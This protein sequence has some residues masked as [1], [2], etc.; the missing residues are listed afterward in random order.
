MIGAVFA[1]RAMGMQEELPVIQMDKV[2]LNKIADGSYTG[3][4]L[5]K[6]VKVVVEVTVKDN[7]IIDI[8]IMKHDNGLGKKAE[9]IVDQIIKRQSLDV[10]V[11]SGATSSSKAILK[12]VEVAL[13]K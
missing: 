13:S 1:I 8:V 9:K 12:A 10:E 4:Y 5:G 6:L 2:E 3:E 7:K 11:V